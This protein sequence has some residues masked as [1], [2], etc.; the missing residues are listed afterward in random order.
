MTTLLTSKSTKD[1]WR[2]SLKQTWSNLVFEEAEVESVNRNLQT[3]LQ[4]SPG[5]WGLY[6]ATFNELEIRESPEAKG[7]TGRFAY[8]RMH[9]HK[10]AEMHFWIPG[11]RGFEK[12]AWGIPEPALEGAK[13]V[14]AESLAG[15]VI[16]G[17]AFDRRGVRLGRGKGYYDRYLAKFQGLRVGVIPEQMLV[18]ELPCEDFDQRMDVVV[19]ERQILRI[20]K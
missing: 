12:N 19:T 2:K 9:D 11:P 14:G 10:N 15:L 1:D 6:F 8:P 20:T 4:E 16:P 3:V 17:L 13:E 18:Q 5:V 7:P